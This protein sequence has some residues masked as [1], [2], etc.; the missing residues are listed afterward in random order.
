[1]VTIV[2]TTVGTTPVVDQLFTFITHLTKAGHP[3]LAEH[4]FIRPVRDGLEIHVLELNELAAFAATFPNPLIKA[5]YYDLAGS[6][7][8]FHVLCI[9]SVEDTNFIIWAYVPAEQ[10]DTAQSVVAAIRA[11]AA[12]TREGRA[13]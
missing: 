13:L 10:D 4:V 9:E 7:P 2:E 12:A 3:E 11:G 5:R 1:M 6:K 8:W